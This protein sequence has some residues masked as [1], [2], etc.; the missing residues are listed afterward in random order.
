MV[1]DR[2]G[3]KPL[4]AVAETPPPQRPAESPRI[5]ATTVA[6]RIVYRESATSSA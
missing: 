1:E 5:A 6:C 2:H 3:V 4:P